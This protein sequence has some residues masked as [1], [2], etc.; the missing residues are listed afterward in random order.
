M[1]M[2]TK[3]KTW[4]LHIDGGGRIIATALTRESLR[5]LRPRED[6]GERVIEVAEVRATEQE[7]VDDG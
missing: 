1:D 4:W 6:E 3:D 2:Q 5:L 7:S